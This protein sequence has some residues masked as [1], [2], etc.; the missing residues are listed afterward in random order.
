MDINTK[1]YR[2]PEMADGK[3]DNLNLPN[4][5]DDYYKMTIHFYAQGDELSKEQL[6][7][8]SRRQIHEI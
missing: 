7:V 6:V 3:N 4:A 2:F 1:L 8:Y 5:G